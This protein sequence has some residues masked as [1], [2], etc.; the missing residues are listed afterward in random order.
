MSPTLIP[1]TVGQMLKSFALP[2]L[3]ALILFNSPTALADGNTYQYN[4]PAQSLN[5]ALMQFAADSNLKLL[6]TADTVR[7]MNT[8]G[9]NGNMTAA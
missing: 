6:L 1:L 3:A 4:I 8:E 2:A 7:G 9:L 5:N